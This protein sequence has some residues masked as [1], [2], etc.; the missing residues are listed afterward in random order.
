[1]YEI[2]R[3]HEQQKDAE[4]QQMMQQLADQ[5]EYTQKV[6][7]ERSE[8][9]E[10]LSKANPQIEEYKI[11]LENR[12]Q[13]IDAIN[14]EKNDHISMLHNQVRDYEES[15]T[16]LKQWL[17]K[18]KSDYKLLSLEN[19]TLQEMFEKKRSTQRNK[20]ETPSLNKDQ[21]N[22][23]DEV[24]VGSSINI[25]VPRYNTATPLPRNR[26]ESVQ[27]Y[28]AAYNAIGIN[29]EE[30][31]DYSNSPCSINGKQWFYNMIVIYRLI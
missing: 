14:K 28:R 15:L 25:S 27:R 2:H 4:I 20:V 19:S 30:E 13:E 3:Q 5:R 22:E 17:D 10:L 23:G 18:V 11:L 24:L 12:E 31:N 6:E 21:K 8:L 26:S 16:N 29:Y 7:Y 1:M 9:A